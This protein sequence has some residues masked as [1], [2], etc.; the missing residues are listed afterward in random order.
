MVWLGSLNVSQIRR[1]YWQSRDNAPL[2]LTGQKQHKPRRVLH[3]K[4]QFSVMAIGD[5]AWTLSMVSVGNP[6]VTRKRLCSKARP[7]IGKSCPVP[8][9]CLG[10]MWTIVALFQWKNCNKNLFG[11]LKVKTLYF[12]SITLLPFFREVCGGIF[13]FTSSCLTNDRCFKF[14]WTLI[15]NLAYS[16]CLQSYKWLTK[17]RTNLEFRM[18]H[19]VKIYQ[20][21]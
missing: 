11:R 2:P 21:F 16:L 12:M 17:Y 15:S 4:E 18:W 7:Y 6:G 10:Y 13:P 20:D 1:N 8:Q 9:S 3:G 5:K 14:N 19:P